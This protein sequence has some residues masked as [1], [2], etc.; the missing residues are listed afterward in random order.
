MCFTPEAV[1]RQS[2][3]TGGAALYK[4]LPSKLA[5]QV[6]AMGPPADLT[7]TMGRFF[8]HDPLMPSTRT[9]LDPIIAMKSWM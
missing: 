6:A 4:E 2:D 5:R 1:A 3:N 9:M 8:S 7:R